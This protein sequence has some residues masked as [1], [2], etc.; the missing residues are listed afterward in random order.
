MFNV[1]D[2]VLNEEQLI[3]V[4]AHLSQANWV[5]GKATATAAAKDVKK[6]VQTICKQAGDIVIPALMSNEEFLESA[7][8]AKLNVPLFSKYH[9]NMYYGKHIDDPI[10][11]YGGRVLRCDIAMTLFLSDPN[12]YDGGE[13]YVNTGEPNVTSHKLPA[14]SLLM[15]PADSYHYIAEV[16]EGMRQVMVTWAQSFIR[17]HDKRQVLQEL[18]PHREDPAIDHAYGKLVRM[19]SDV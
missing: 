16:T 19:W 6:N 18:F 14:G 7:Y 12:E 5:E 3:D 2:N 17:D 15:Y 4:N 8:L 13:L 9:P 10:M 11:A 1:I